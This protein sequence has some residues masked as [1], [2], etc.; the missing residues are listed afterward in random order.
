MKTITEFTEGVVQDINKARK[1]ARGSWYTFLK[2]YT[3]GA[4]SIDVR[5]KGYKT[6][7]QVFSINGIIHSSGADISVSEL[8]HNIIEAIEYHL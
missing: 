7:L 5:I 4:R 2:T 3:Y 8:E 1:A 6:W